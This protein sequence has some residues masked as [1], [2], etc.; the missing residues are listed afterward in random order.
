MT[1]RRRGAA[2]APAAWPGRAAA[3]AA[4]GLGCAVAAL[5][6]AGADPSAGR[7]K[8]GAC[9]ACHGENG[10]SVQPDAPHLAGQPAPYVAAQLRLYRSGKRAHE[11]MAVIARPL[12]DADIDD[13]AAWFAAIPIEARPPK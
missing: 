7:R 1:R 6:A 13:L 8:A 2:A 9:V 10:L 11:V 3:L 4:F 5:P 12:S